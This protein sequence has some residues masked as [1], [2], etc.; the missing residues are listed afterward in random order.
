MSSSIN[1][2]QSLVLHRDTVRPEWVDEYDHM[3]LAYYILVCDQ[4][5]YEFW[6]LIN[7]RKSISDRNGM[8]YAVVETH[9]NYIREVRLNDPLV[10]ATQLLGFDEKRF[11]IFHEL[12]HAEQ[13]FISA[14]NEIMALGFD[15]NLRGIEPFQDSVQEF[16]KCVYNKHK[17]LEIPENAGRSIGIKRKSR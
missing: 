7:D 2:D 1:F 14:T 16:M 10:V 12:R 3:N 8:E 6:E 15:L 5:T 4:A 9:V 17:L 13:G 11:H